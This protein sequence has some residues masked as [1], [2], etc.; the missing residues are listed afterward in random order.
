MFALAILWRKEKVGTG[1][2]KCLTFRTCLM[3]GYVYR[4]I[5]R[6]VSAANIA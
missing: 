3:H 6:H 2:G 4:E 1:G 5:T